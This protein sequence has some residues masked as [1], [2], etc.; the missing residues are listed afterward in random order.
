MPTLFRKVHFYG[1]ETL[2]INGLKKL[3]KFIPYMVNSN[4]NPGVDN[5]FN[6]NNACGSECDNCSEVFSTGND[7]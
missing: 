6:E 7:L 4:L 3:V 5:Y 2:S 1:K